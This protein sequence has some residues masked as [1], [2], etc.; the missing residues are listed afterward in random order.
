MNWTDLVIPIERLKL[1]F[2]NAGLEPPTGM[3]LPF[4]TYWQI[5]AS[6]DP[7]DFTVLG[8]KHT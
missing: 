3:V 2:L 7:R 8:S 4:D 6:M 1:V 5:R